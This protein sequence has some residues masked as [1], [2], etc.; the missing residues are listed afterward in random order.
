MADIKH[1]P[2]QT[3][4]RMHAVRLW[5]GLSVPEF[6][7]AFDVPRANALPVFKGRNLPQPELIAKMRRQWGITMD[8]LI[9]DEADGLPA[10]FRENLLE[11]EARGREAWEEMIRSRTARRA[12]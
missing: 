5:K 10:D 12:S 2:D 7:K 8:Y 3:A 9:L 4:V 1:T 6:Y 11:W